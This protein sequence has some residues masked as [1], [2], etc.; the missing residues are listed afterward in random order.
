MSRW[1]RFYDD[2][3]NDP[4]V[5][6]LSGDD[7]KAWVNLLCLASKNEGRLPSIDDMAFAL[8]RSPNDVQ[9]V[10]ERLLNGGLI[11]RRNGGPN[12]VHYAPHGWDKRQY[13]SDTSTQRVQRFRKRF[14]AV[15]EA[16]PETETETDKEAN[17]SLDRAPEQPII[18]GR[19]DDFVSDVEA[20]ALGLR[21]SAS[22]APDVPLPQPA[23]KERAPPKPRKTQMPEAFELSETMTAIA[24]REGRTHA[25]I[26]RDFDDFCGYCRA[27]GS[28]YA[29]WNAAWRNWVSKAARGFGQPRRDASRGNGS[30]GVSR[31]E[32]YQRGAARIS[33]A[34]NVPG[35]WPD[36]RSG[37]E[38]P[39]ELPDRKAG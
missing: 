11:D 23:A 25:E 10:V 18:P 35:E 19:S 1:F 26:R 5:Q 16:A 14:D 6:L 39:L 2:A 28:A 30:A 32:A 24:L 34:E 8:R 31:L 27:H 3:L 4:K 7:F 33:D 21:R 36:L 15:S 29:D 38:R 20:V 12:G 9:T 17:A 13:K 22:P 37:R